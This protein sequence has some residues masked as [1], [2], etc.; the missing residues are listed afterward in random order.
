MIVRRWPNTTSILHRGDAEEAWSRR[1]DQEFRTPPAGQ[2]RVGVA[3]Y[4]ALF[5]VEKSLAAKTFGVL[6]QLVERLNGIEQ[7]AS[8]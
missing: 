7:L 1:G 6:A 3:L 5:S 2:K 8:M 4:E